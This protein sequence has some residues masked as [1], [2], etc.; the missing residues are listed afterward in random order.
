MPHQNTRTEALTQAGLNLIQQALSIFD[1]DLNLKVCNRPYQEMFDLPP[2][3][4]APGAKFEDTIRHLVLR[5]EYGPVDDVDAF[6]RARVD[7]ALAFESHYVE[8]TRAN[9]QTISIEGNPLPQGGWVAVYTDITNIKNQEQLLRARSEELSEQVLEHSEQLRRTNRE[10]AATIMQLEETKYELTEMESRTRMTTEMMPAHIAHIDRDGYYT[11]S[12][13]QLKSVM[14]GRAPNIIG[15]TIQEVL[16]TST[17]E[18]IKPY[19]QKACDGEPSVCEFTDEVSDNRVRL[20]LTPDIDPD[21]PKGNTR[22]VYILSTD[23]TEETQTRI[24]LMHSNKRELA[25]QLTSG[26]AHDFANL[27]TIILGTQSRLSKFGLPK[28]A[29]DLIE[30]TRNAARR[31]GAL[32]NR[33]S[34]LSNPRDMK[35]KATNLLA[36]LEDIKT[37]AIP[38]L[39]KI[40]TLDVT[41]DKIQGPLL[42]DTPS[43]QDALINLIINARDAIG[44]RAGAI[45]IAAKPVGDKWLDISVADTGGGFSAEALSKAL[46]PFFTTKGDAGSGL[47]LPMVYD[48]AQL[49]GGRVHIRNTDTGARVSLRL[50]LKAI[51]PKPD[52]KLILLVEDTPDIRIAVREMLTDLGHSVIEA[53]SADEAL[54]IAKLTEVDLILTDILLFGEKTGLD[55]LLALKAKK[56][57]IPSYMMTSLPSHDP[58]RQRA[59]SHFSVLSKPFDENVLAAFLEAD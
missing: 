3:L 36:L 51:T 13:L 40:I 26:M 48:V 39:P 56:I 5:D 23:V 10:L 45:S 16:G 18:K 59:E 24:A 47:G 27:L 53:E 50:P 44:T 28:D 33:L 38:S 30:A 46:D 57:H 54:E 52:P 41:T 25:A 8:R 55:F 35:P 37:I 7:Q 32:L 49:S 20:A 11:F 22:G 15:R 29:A 34:E 4:S 17:F 12:N 2:E 6:V 9:G 14:P 58:R 1:E 21:D 42:L 19:L 31:G 43:L